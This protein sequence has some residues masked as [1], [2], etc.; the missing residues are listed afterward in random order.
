MKFAKF[1]GGYFAHNGNSHRPQV[2]PWQTFAM[3]VSGNRKVKKLAY[4]AHDIGLILL[5]FGTGGVFGF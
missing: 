2:L 4:L 1:N 5:K 3:N